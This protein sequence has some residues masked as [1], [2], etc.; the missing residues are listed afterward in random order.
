MG[1]SFFFVFPVIL[2][3]SLNERYED[4]RK[5]KKGK[6]DLTGTHHTGD[7]PLISGN[8][9]YSCFGGIEQAISNL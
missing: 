4:Q 9:P 1:L 7:E 5:I 3:L 2:S 8:E 6:N